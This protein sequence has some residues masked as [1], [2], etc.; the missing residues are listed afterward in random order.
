MSDQKTTAVIIDD[1]ELARIS[2]RADIEDHCPHIDIIG[3]ADGVVAGA[4]L[5]KQA[6]PDIVFLDIE[7]NDG[8]GFDL[9]D[10]VPNLESKVIFVTGSSEYA[11]K[12]FQ[13]SAID[14]IMKPVEADL[15]IKAVEKVAL[16]NSP[17]AE[18][19]D[20][21]KSNYRQ[22]K[23]SS[24][25]ALHTTEQ[26]LVTDIKDIIRLES[27]G[28][29]TQFYFADGSKI[30]ITKTLKTYDSLLTK[31]GFMRVHQSHLVNLEYV[32]AYVKTEGGYLT[33]KDDSMVPVSVRK[34]PLVVERLG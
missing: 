16:T 31:A 1:I 26:I 27:T 4:K 25:L 34:K 18:Q 32:K 20:L 19:V 8:I 24:K 28:N 29:Y 22:S 2:L 9:L 15:L 13:Y 7:M 14:Y 6:K 21:L 23:P 5:L 17:T 11:I 30:L 33:M 12:A 3:E 10:I